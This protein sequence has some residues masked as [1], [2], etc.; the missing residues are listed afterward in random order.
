MFH[1]M[2]MKP[3]TSCVTFVSVGLS[4]S[5]RPKSRCSNSPFPL[6]IRY[7]IGYAHVLRILCGSLLSRYMFSIVQIL[8]TTSI[9]IHTFKV[10]LGNLCICRGVKS[11]AQE[12]EAKKPRCR[13]SKREY[14]DN[15]PP[16]NFNYEQLLLDVGQHIFFGWHSNSLELTHIGEKEA[17]TFRNGSQQCQT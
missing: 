12:K 11:K 7:T 14:T 9:E 16:E 2:Q 10:P 1:V 13:H 4:V 15:T 5:H 6:L 17:H 8:Q 3:W